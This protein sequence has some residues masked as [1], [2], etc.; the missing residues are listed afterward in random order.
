MSH[1][2]HATPPTLIVL[3]R[4]NLHGHLEYSRFA[5]LANY[6]RGPSLWQIFRRSIGILI[7]PM[8]LSRRLARALI[9]LA[10]GAIFLHCGRGLN[11]SSG[12]DLNPA[13]D[14]GTSQPLT[15]SFVSPASAGRGTLLTLTG[16]GFRVGTTVTIGDTACR[17]ITRISS[18]V[19]TCKVPALISVPQDV[20]VAHPDAGTAT[21]AEAFLY[22]TFVYMP[23]PTTEDVSAFSFDRDSGVLTHI[24]GSPYDAP[25]RPRIGTFLAGGELLYLADSDFSGPNV[26]EVHAAIINGL[27]GTIQSINPVLDQEADISA[28]VSDPFDDI[29]LFSSFAS[30]RLQAYRP[31]FTTGALTLASEADLNFPGNKM[32]IL[33]NGRFLYVLDEGASRLYGYSFNR[34][35]GAFTALNSVSTPNSAAATAAHPNGK[36]VYVVSLEGDSVARYSIDQNTGALA[37]LG[38][39]TSVSASPQ[40]LTFTPN[41]QFAYVAGHA[42]AVIQRFSVNSDT[43]ALTALGTFDAESSPRFLATDPEGRF[44]YSIQNLGTFEAFQI[45][46]DGSLTEFDSS[47]ST[48]ANGGPILFR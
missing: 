24:S 18:T 10:T 7:T 44:L 19:L 43:G 16:T 22:R 40:Y 25:L 42:D 21:L 27:D 39:P 37:S 11:P 30:E 36:F 12:T 35:T 5:V 20:S 1:F 41:G 4:A 48:I 45:Q 47:V 3:P 28:F 46:S 34:E 23:S 15:L 33:A 8:R 9:T 2:E 14:D 32:V 38:A 6:T 13:D 17:S 31:N 26:G 29:L